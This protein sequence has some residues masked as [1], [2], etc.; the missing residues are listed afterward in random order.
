MTT[1]SR[2]HATALWEARF[3]SGLLRPSYTTSWDTIFRGIPSLAGP[4]GK[5]AEASGTEK[6]DR[7][8]AAASRR[9]T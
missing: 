1:A 9:S 4:N 2:S 5:A 8:A 7:D 6:S 3:A